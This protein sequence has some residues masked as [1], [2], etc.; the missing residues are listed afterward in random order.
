[1]ETVTVRDIGFGFSKPPRPPINVAAAT[2]FNGEPNVRL[3]DYLKSIYRLEHELKPSSEK[4]LCESIQ[5]F[6]TWLGRCAMLTDLNEQTVNQHLLWMSENGRRPATIH[7]RRRLLL[8]FWR[9]AWE[10]ELIRDLP[11]RVRKIKLPPS[12]PDAWTP[13]EV[14]QLVATCRNLK[15]F[16]SNGISKARFWTSL[17]LAAWDT[18]LRLGDLLTFEA[19][20]LAA[21]GRQT[22]IQN[23]TGYEQFVQL[24]PSTLE[25]IASALEDQ[26]SR[27][28]IWAWPSRRE[29]FYLAFKRIVNTAGIRPGTFR[30]LRRGSITAVDVIKRG[31]GTDHAGHRDRA[32]TV[33]HYID[34][35]QYEDDRPMPPEVC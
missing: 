5:A 22:V 9:A 4:V 12:I 6:S 3:I 35:R 26:S 28:L 7:S 30:W 29:E 11:R 19:R 32:T 13:D 1:M 21:G 8:T 17:A 16:M 25:A 23:K 24:R 31:A 2:L 18:G 20:Q 14:R 33:R 34:Q 15:G 27:R 10:A